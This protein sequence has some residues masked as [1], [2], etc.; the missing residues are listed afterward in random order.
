MQELIKQL[1]D[2]EQK[3]LVLLFHEEL[4]AEEIALVLGISF[5]DVLR[6]YTKAVAS[7]KVSTRAKCLAK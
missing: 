2:L 6:L 4:N 5:Y 1:P 7:L 3:V